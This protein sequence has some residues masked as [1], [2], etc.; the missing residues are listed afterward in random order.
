MNGSRLRGLLIA[1]FCGAFNDNAW[2]LMVALLAIRQ[3]ASTM[4][5][6]PDFETASQTQ[7]TKAFVVFTLPLALV[8]I[9][10]GVF[11]DRVSKR[12][13][14]ILMKSVEMLLMTS[15]TAALWINP[16]GGILPLVVLAGMGIHS[17]LFSPAKYGILAELVPH[18]KLAAGN[19]RLEMWTFLAILTGTA[20]PGIL[21]SLTGD[22]TWLAPLVLAGISVIG[23][24]A[25]WTI[26][27]VP[28]ARAAGG[29]LDTLHGA[30]SALAADRMLRLAV[31]G[32]VFFWTIASLFAQNILVYAK[33]VLGVSDW[34]S[35][36]PLMMLSIGIGLGARLV[37]R[38]S[39][40]RVEYGLIPL[41]ATGVALILSSLGIF[42]PAFAVTLALMVVLGLS[43]AL[44]FVPLNALIQWRAPAE[45]RGSVI[46]FENICVFS[47]IMI[48]SLGAGALASGGVS[49]TGIFFTTAIFTVAGTGWALYLLPEA[50]LRVLLVVLTNTIYRLRIVGH[51]HVPAQGGALLV[52]NH[53]S[54]IDGLLL[55]ASLDRPVRFV[56][57][58]AYAS[59][60][61]YKP[62]M[63]VLGVIPISSQAGLRVV[64]R[65]LRDA[66]HAI[67]RGDLVCVFPEGQITR[68]GT[69]LPFRRGFERI[70]KGKTAP[71]V[72]VHLDR[73]WGSIFS[74]DHGRFL[75]KI[76]ERLPYPVTVSYGAPLPSDTSAD[77]LR[78]TIRELGEEAWTHR[79]KDRRPLHREFIRAMRRYPF[80][81]AMADQRRPHVSSLQALIGSIV[82]ARTF[83]PIWEGQERVGI[84][85]PPTVAAA[86]LNVAA[87]LCGKTSVNLNY[88]VGKAGLEAAVRLAGLRTIVTSR[89]FV[90]KAKLD[91]PEGP[92]IIWLED[93]AQTIGKGAKLGAAILALCAP[94]RIIERV[95]GQTTPLTMDDPAT[96]IF[97]SGSTGDPKG[98]MLTHFNIDANAQGASQVL[99]VIQEE[100]V[101]GILPFF[102]SF[103]YLVFWF[104][105]YNNAALIFHPSPL[106][107]TAIGE[108]IRK[109]RV[110]FLVTTP[111]F[112]QLYQRRCTPEQ[113]SS[114]R[115]VLTGAEKLPA[116]LSQAFQ[117]QFGIGPIEG[118]GVTECSPV[119]AV[120]CPDFRA[121]GFFQP[122]SRRGTVGQPLPGV[123]VQVVDPEQF[124]P[125]TPGHPGM[126]LVKGP[127]VM[128]GYLGRDDLTASVMHDGWYITGDIAT[129]D[130]DGFLTITDRL[131][132]FS[133]IG[134]EMVPHGRVEEVL[135][136][137]A[138][139]DVQL[140]AVTGIPDEKKGERLA[141]L[142]TLDEARI[143][144]ILDKVT[145][146]GLPN[147]F[148][149]SRSQ[150]VKVDAL[151]LLGTGKLDLRAVKRIAMERLAQP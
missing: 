71:I 75:W 105:M 115:V 9:F 53:V 39:Q 138:A 43:S 3:L 68:T 20:A 134:G 50:L 30:W 44:I 67:D 31:A 92:S 150:F 12:T 100:R 90:E 65:A 141:V 145:A 73:V 147:L 91:L 45:R 108:L 34:Q 109:Y 148:I 117:D 28:P 13:V 25:A 74:F 125:L 124:T 116:R 63:K 140:F 119:I 112:L 35:G 146:Q 10:A 94:A 126:L 129:L 144:E 81:L 59:H 132:R 86:L 55:I 106:D 1:Q 122:A 99:H 87:P 79:K 84:L 98:V 40:S 123:S 80:R 60:P 4:G 37:G 127:N 58:D 128:N 29:L 93:A 69:L 52:P 104:A 107:V 96:I 47:G 95:C 15:A 36:L 23:F 131:S 56:V 41:G 51:H 33:A 143:A 89:T 5:P 120:N 136:E 2:K 114:L 102:H 54:F 64:L 133:K 17:A 88:T 118:Y 46:A 7:T 130:D 42:A 62:F 110:T 76:P 66:G 21:L 111:T 135:Q 6:G 27:S 77:D 103:G 8:S 19:G 49:T 78:Q 113:F 22:S 72:P 142:H 61:L 18:E 97:S 82:L 16:A 14:I 38:L 101:L 149:P 121:A 70:M 32:N 24:S 137:A 26:P 83:R 85:L 48:G 57:D 139:G 11:A 151:P